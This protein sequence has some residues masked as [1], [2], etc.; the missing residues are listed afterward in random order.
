MAQFTNSSNSHV[1]NTFYFNAGQFRNC[2]VDIIDIQKKTF[3]SSSYLKKI[4]NISTLNTESNI[5]S[6][7]IRVRNILN[8]LFSSSSLNCLCELF[9]LKK[10]F[11][12]L[13]PFNTTSSLSSIYVRLKNN[14][15]S[16]TADSNITSNIRKRI[17]PSFK[18][19]SNTDLI[20]KVNRTCYT[21]ISTIKTKS[22]FGIE[23]FGF[24]LYY[25]GK[26]KI[27]ICHKSAPHHPEE[28][29][30]KVCSI[31][32]KEKYPFNSFIIKSWVL[33]DGRCESSSYHF[34]TTE[35][36]KE[37]TILDIHEIEE[38]VVVECDNKHSFF[39]TST[40]KGNSISL[41]PV[42][43]KELKYN[44]NKIFE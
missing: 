9:R 16:L 26:L 37:N 31:K 43:G 19:G 34:D 27:V 32:R 4:F 24:L 23:Y 29:E 3:V 41:T 42:V 14:L 21:N 35:T 13:V 12:S 1:L 28:L 44:G 11:L 6:K 7:S 33:N 8:S 22:S 30:Y 40:T 18:L 20:Y 2:T 36:I 25:K 15:T 39:F 10:I 5:N 17:G 38:P